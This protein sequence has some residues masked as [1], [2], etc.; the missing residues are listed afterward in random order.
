M[1][2]DDKLYF[3]LK[4]C[5][6]TYMYKTNTQKIEKTGK[7]KLLDKCNLRKYKL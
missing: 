4:E 2:L 3:S 6:K 1:L 5:L 7:L